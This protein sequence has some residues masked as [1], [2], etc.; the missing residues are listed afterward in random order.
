MIILAVDITADWRVIVDNISA[1]FFLVGKENAG[2]VSLRAFPATREMAKAESARVL[3]VT[4][5]ATEKWLNMMLKERRIEPFKQGPF[6]TAVD[7]FRCPEDARHRAAHDDLLVSERDLFAYL[8]G[9]V[10]ACADQRR[11][12]EFGADVA[13][14]VALF[15]QR[16]QVSRPFFGH[17][18]TEG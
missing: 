2:K 4:N 16:F 6:D 9:D 5:S 10:L 11:S 12:D 17:P 15:V 3:G 14:S 7:L 8:Q 1:T 13:L 18:G